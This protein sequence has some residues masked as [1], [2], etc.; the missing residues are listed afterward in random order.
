[1][2]EAALKHLQVEEVSKTK[3]SVSNNHQGLGNTSPEKKPE[4]LTKD[5]LTEAQLARMEEKKEKIKAE[6]KA[7]QQTE[8]KVCQQGMFPAIAVSQYKASL[9]AS[10]PK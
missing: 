3:A 9:R 10:T 6:V 5:T 7:K 4:V 2:V 1:M 8:A